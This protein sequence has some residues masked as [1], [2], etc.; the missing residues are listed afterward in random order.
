LALFVVA[1]DLYVDVCW[2]QSLL[3]ACFVEPYGCVCSIQFSFGGLE[4]VDLYCL[5]GLNK[6]NACCSVHLGNKGNYLFQL[7]VHFLMFLESLLL[8][9]R[10]VSDI[11]ASI[12]R[13]TTVVYAA[14]GL[15]FWCVYS[16]RSLLVF[17]HITVSRSVLDCFKQYWWM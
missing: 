3:P 11:T 6:F 7:N 10:H 17:F 14:I 16:V 9:T 4:L 15:W 5:F 2:C 1:V 8:F 13:S 12:I